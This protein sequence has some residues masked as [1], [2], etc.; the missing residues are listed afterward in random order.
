VNADKIEIQIKS[1]V[2]VDLELMA[3]RYPIQS[4]PIHIAFSRIEIGS[5]LLRIGSSLFW[6]KSSLFVKKSSR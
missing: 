3:A 5:S 1:T 4:S 2:T 6:M